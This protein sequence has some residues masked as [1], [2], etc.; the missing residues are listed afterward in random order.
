[1]HCCCLAHHR[2]LSGELVYYIYDVYLHT[3]QYLAYRSIPSRSCGF[4]V[5]TFFNG[6]LSFFTQAL[7]ISIHHEHRVFKNSTS[8]IHVPLHAAQEERLE[9]SGLIVPRNNE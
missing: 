7:L 9:I 8:N 5:R 3:A 4:G 2:E 6:H 1:M